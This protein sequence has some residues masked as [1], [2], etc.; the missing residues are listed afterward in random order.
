MNPWTKPPYLSQHE[1]DQF[2]ELTKTDMW[3]RTALESMTLRGEVFGDAL[4]KSFMGLA[5]YHATVRALRNREDWHEDRGPVLWW[6]VP[7]TEP[8]HCGTPFDQDFPEYCTHW[9][10]LPI[11]EIQ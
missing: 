4:F 1:W 9:T 10:V 11:P 3:A 7:I 2:V 8:P 5:K 6:T